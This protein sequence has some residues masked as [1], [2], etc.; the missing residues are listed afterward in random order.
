VRLRV[1]ITA[2]ITVVAAGL[3]AAPSGLAAAAAD[4]EIAGLQVALRSKGLYFG[5]IDG[6]AGPMTAK[7]LRSFQRLTG[8]P[9]TGEL[10]PRTRAQLGALGRPLVA[11]RVLVQGTY[12]WDVSA[13]QFLLARAGHLRLLDVDGHFGASTKAAVLRFQ[14]SRKLAADGVAGPA[15]RTAFGQGRRTPVLTRTPSAAAAASYL[16]RPGDTLTAIAT[17]HKTTVRVL[18]KVNNLSPEGVLLEGKKLRL[19]SAGAAAVELSKS[20]V[21]AHI[22]RWATRYGVPTNLARALAWQ[23]SGFQTNITS[24]VGAW[25]PMQVMPTTWTFVETVLLG[26][27]VPR[28]GEGGVEVGMALLA[29]LLKR[30]DGDQRLAIAAWYQGEKAVRER[31]LYDETKTF[32]ANVLALSG[33]RI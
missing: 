12:G 8:L 7:G 28:T 24:S 9:V 22:D 26:R 25:G 18:A 21:R 17:K 4:P 13:L 32:V 30:F 6:R 31:G 14:R 2:V 29:H 33:R 11:R 19:P 16:V 15:T 1:V 5:K 3:L 27:N 20:T 23:E 10:G